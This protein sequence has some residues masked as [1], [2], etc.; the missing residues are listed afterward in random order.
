[1]LIGIGPR[2]PR[3]ATER[4][5]V[6][7]RKISEMDGQWRILRLLRARGWKTRVWDRGECRS[8]IV[9]TGVYKDR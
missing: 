9:E 7:R 6:G 8:I 3:R 4:G 1:M 2:G 5:P